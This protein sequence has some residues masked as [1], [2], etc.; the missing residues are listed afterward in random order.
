MSDIGKRRLRLG[1]IGGGGIMTA[2]LT[3]A[4]LDGQYELVAG[5]FSSDPARSKRMG[6]TLYLDPARAYGSWEEM[7]D[8]ESA[9]PAAA[10]IDA[11]SIITPNHLHFGPAKTALEKGFH[12]IL[13]KPLTLTMRE[14]LD[15][16]DAVRKSGRILA[17]THAYASCAMVK[18]ARDM[19]RHGM[20]GTVRKVVV[21]YPQG[22]LHRLAE[23]EKANKAAV[24]RTD[25]ALAGTGCIGDIGTHAAQLSE[26]VVGRPVTAVA[27]DVAAVVPGR[28][29]DDDFT[30]L[31]RWGDDVRGSIQASQISTGES[32]GL[33]IRVYGDKAGLE[34]NQLDVDNLTL[35][36]QDQPWQTWCR[37][38]PYVNAVSPAAAQ[39]S[40][41]YANHT[42]GYIEEFANIYL[43]V[44]RAIRAVEAGRT[45]NDLELDFPCIDDGVRGM[46]FIE[47]VLES[48][49]NNS[50]WTAVKQY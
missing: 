24:W 47:A 21:E 41:V 48:A 44:S 30:A 8:R 9:L 20:L 28:K 39:V 34:W 26:T 22:W 17:V 13:D 23:S 42:E 14:A 35:M 10:R 16:R 7:L 25:P 50:T 27:A 31:A 1:M 3:G 5:A 45:P 37:N 49:R 40:R 19:I 36:F 2:H 29:T 46:A 11:V 33:R 32:N 12:V 15:L 6:E 18:A 43:N 38:A 4:R